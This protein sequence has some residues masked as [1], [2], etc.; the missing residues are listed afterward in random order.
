MMPP[1]QD[2]RTLTFCTECGKPLPSNAAFCSACGSPVH[3]SAITDEPA[4]TPSD[5]TIPAPPSA[6]VDSSNDQPASPPPPSD[7]APATPTGPVVV[8]TVCRN[9][10]EPGVPVCA[11][12][13]TPRDGSSSEGEE[14]DVVTASNGNKR[15]IMFAGIG[16]VAVVA[17]IGGWLAWQSFGTDSADTALPATTTSIDQTST[18]VPPSTSSTTSTTA[19]TTTAPT[20]TTTTLPGYLVSDLAGT[21]VFVEPG[22]DADPAVLLDAVDDARSHNWD[23]SVVALATEPADG[24]SAYAGMVALETD[25]GTVLVAAPQA[26]GWATQETQFV[27]G[28]FERA[29]S[30]IPTDSDEDAAVQSFVRSVLGGPDSVGT[31]EVATAHWDLLRFDDSIVSFA[32]GDADDFPFVGDWDCDGIAT[33]GIWR[34]DTQEIFLRNSNTGGKAK[35]SYTYEADGVQPIVGDFD[36]DGCDTVS[37]YFP[38][39]GSV[40]IFN[41]KESSVGQSEEGAAVDA[42]YSFG[43][44]G[45][46]AFVGDFDGDGIDTLGLF[47]PSSGMVY[48]NNTHEA[49]KADI[50]FRFGDSGDL[51]IAGDWGPEDGIDTIALYRP[52]TGEFFFRYTNSAGPADTTLTYGILDGYPVAGA[53]GLDRSG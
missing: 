17:I 13:G 40:L 21:G 41:T 38:D 9:P 44:A 4:E 28:E 53:F 50:E 27:E 37:F 43:A 3:R 26:F 39:D 11:A 7:P 24:V 34:A 25:A 22:S 52:A 8:C 32:F 36:G 30:L 12:C 19:P 42:T 29:W 49:G 23:L 31:V 5:L 51:P 6:P 18:K 10:L 15:T 33:P 14:P 48:L 46:I 2:W 20:P 1:G 16:A 47:R 35:I 45:D